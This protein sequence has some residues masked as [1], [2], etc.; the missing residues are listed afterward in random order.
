[1]PMTYAAHR[2]IIDAATLFLSIDEDQIRNLERA[3]TTEQI[4]YVVFESPVVFP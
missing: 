4:G 3:H 1:M 2:K